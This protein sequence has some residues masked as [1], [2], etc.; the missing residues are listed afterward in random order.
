MSCTIQR[1]R[2]KGYCTSVC[3]KTRLRFHFEIG[4][5]KGVVSFR[6]LSLPHHSFLYNG[7]LF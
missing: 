5:D 3:K 6:F 1:E 4:T 7:V 2:E